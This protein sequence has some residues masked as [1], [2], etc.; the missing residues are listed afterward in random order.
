M[1]HREDSFLL[2]VLDEQDD[3]VADLEKIRSVCETILADLAVRSGRMNVV[4]ADSSTIRQY[5]KDFLQ[6]DYPTDVISF[7]IEDRRSEGHLEGEVLVCTKV[8]KERAGEFGWSAEE[9]LLLYIVHGVL[10]LVGFDDITPELKEE[11]QKN[12]R[13]Y[14]NTLGITVPDWNWDDWD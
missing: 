13:K 10:H 11:M 14:L 1:P 7:P 2:E 5:N 4:L 3:L 8:A 12:E 6:H 9:E